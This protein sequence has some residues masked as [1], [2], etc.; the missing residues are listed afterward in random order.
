MAKF[1]DIRELAQQNARWVSNS[2]KDW[3]NYLDVAARLYRYSFKDTLL[4]HA[5]R[6]DA[7]ACAEL[8][9]WNKKMNRWVNRGAKG[10]AL[11]D[12][13]SPRA[14]LRY[15]FDI[16]DTHLVQG[17]RTPILWRIDD[18]EHQQMILDHLA[19]TY[20]LTQ[21]DSMNAALMELAQQ[22][23]AENLE[24]AMDGL[25]YEVADTFLE[26][27]DEDNLRVRFRE[28]MTNSIFYTLSRRC[29][30]EPLEVLEDEDFIRI[31]DF[32]QLP[33]LTFLGNAVSEQCEAVLF[34]IGREMRKIYKKEITQQLEKSVDSLYNTN[35]DFSTLKHETKENTT[36]GGQENGV[37]VL[38]QGRLSVPESGREGRAADY[39][40]V[41]DAAQ[42][43]PER[44]PQELVSEYADKRQ[45]EPAS[46]ADRG[47]SGEPDGNPA[48]QPE[49]EVS[50]TE[51]GEGPAG[52]GSTSEQ[53][54]GDGRRDRFEGIGVQL[55]ETTT[56]QDLSEAE[57]EI[58]SAFSFPDLPTVE[59][60]IR[61]IEEPIRAR[62]AEKIALDSEVVDEVLRTGSNR[63]K[64][65]LRLIYNFMVEKTP[66][67]Y[68]EFVKNEYGT[69][70]KG[71]EIGGAKYAVWFDDLGLRIA[72]G[73]TAKGG[74]IANASLS[75]EDVSNRIHELLR[76]GEYAPQAVLDAARQN[77]LQE[78]AQ[79][80][81][82]M[83]RDLADG[84][85][86][87]VFQD[88][89][90]FRGGFPELTDRLAG[91]LDDAAFLTDLNERLSALGEAYAEDKDLMRMHF[92]K[93][94]KVAALFQKF[95]KPYQNY[96]ARDGFHWNE[97]KKFITED[98]IN[99]YFTRGSNYSD[100]RLAIYSFFLNHEDKKERADFLKE[101]YGIG[102]SSHALCGADDSHE[103]HDGR[104]IS[105]ERGSYG[106]PDASVHLN[107]NQAAGRIDQLIRDSEYLKPADYSRM[108]AYERERMAM[109]VMGFYHQLPNDVE[110]PYPQ[111][112]Y[113]EEGRKALVEKLEAPE[114][115][116]EL[117]EQMDNALL[118][119]PLDSGEYERKAES[120]SI[121]HQYVE[122]TYTIFPEKKRA[123]E[124]AVPEQ[125]QM[126]MFDFMEQEPQ[127]KEQ[128][129]AAAV[130]KPQKAK[131]VARYQS[132]VM[133]QEGYIE[134]IAILQYPDGKFYNHY[135]YDEEKGTGA[136]ETGPFNS[137]NDAKSVIRQTREDA[138]AVESFENQP[139]QTYSRENGSFLYLENDHLYRV[140]RSNAYDVY[141]KDM[142]N[143]AV[144]G[145]VIPLPSYSETLAKNPLNDFLK[146]DADHTQ[147]DSR[148]VYK[149]CLYT[150]LEKVERSEI[151]PLLRDR[152]TTE[153]EA[154]NLIRE[155]IE[156]LFA[157]GE[158]EN[159][160]Y[161]EAI[162]TWAHFGEWIQEDIFQRTYQDVITDRRDAVALYQDS[163]D[164]PQWVRGIMV[165]YAAEEKAVEPTLQP[166]P[167][168]ETNEYNALK[169]RYPDALVGYE[170]HG[171][172][173]FYG[174][175]AKRV[176]E[177][178]G[179]KLLEKET[180]LGK[181]EVSGFP[182][183]QWASQAMKLW[184]Q[185]ESVYLSGQ[186][187]DGTHAQTKYFR[188]EEYLPINTTIELED[189]EFRV[190]SVNFEQGT[191]SL[192]D[193]TLA[194]EARYPIFRTEP[195]EYIRHVYEQADVPMEEAV[196]I[197]VFTALHNAGV[198][199]EDFSPEQM[200]VI[201]SVAE[202][203]G[204]LEDLLKPEFPP[205]QMQ[206]IAD[207]QNRTDAISRAAAEEALE[208]LTQQPM[209]PAEVNHARR[210]HNLPLDSEAETELPAQPKQEPMNFRITD[211]DLGAG[212]PKAKYKANVEA[213]RVLQTLDAEQ[214]QAA[215]AEE[216][217][218]LSRY[219]GWGGIPQAFDEKNADW[220]KEYAELKSLLPADEYS[221]ARAS[222][223]NAF[224]TSP[225]VIKAMYEALSNMGLSKGNV[226][227]PSCGV[228][229]F[230]GLVPESME[231]IKMYGV[232]LDNVSGRIAQQLYQ[233]NKIA[234]QGFETMQFPDSF[235]D[236]VV[237]NVPFGN[238]KVPDKRYDRHNFLIHDYFIAKSLDLVRP[239][240]VVAVVTSSGTMDKKDSSVRE[241]L[242][243]RADLVGAIRLPNNAFQRNANTSVVADIL[244][245][246]KRDRA[247]VE[248][249]EW[250]DLG[251][252][253]E[254][255]PI[256]QYF[257]Q[258]PEMVLGEITTESTQY[259]KQETTVKPIEGADLA[260]QLKAAVEN[261]NAEITEPEIT[262]D[263]LDQNA[264][265]LPADPNVKNFS[266]TNVDGQVYYR[267]NSYMNKVDLP[268]VTAERVLGMIALRETTQKL[269][270]CQLHDGT[271]AEVELLQGKLKD[272]YKRFTAQYGLINSTA[273]KRAFRQDSSYC[274]LA[275]LEIL[276]EDKNLKRLADIFTKRTIRKPEPVTSVDTPS[277][278]LALSIGEKA[279]V[280]V[281]F[282]AELCGKTEQEVTE[283]LAGVIFRN[284]V[285]Q[286]WVT[287]DEYL[288]G[289]VREKLETAET[290]AANHPEYQVNVEYLKRVQPKDLNASEIEVRL[291]ANWIKAEYITD[292]MERVF[293]T[294]S[295]YIGS[296]IK[297]TYSEISGAWNISGKSLDRSNPR[298]TNTYGTMRVNGYRLLEDALNLRDTK[299][300]D[301]IYEDGK[302]RRVLNKKET[303]L[304][305]QA[306]EAIRDAF[307]QWIFKD[308]D[309]REE[310]C[311]VYN[312]RFNAIRPREYD[313]SHI[314]FVGMTPE[315]SLMPHQKNAV[316]HI[317]Y[318]N[319]TLLA[320]CVGAGKTFQMIAAGMESRRLG[321]AQ[322][323]L[324]VV[325]NH[326]TEQWG[327]DF[328]RLYPNA[329]VLV[330]TKKDFEPA[331]RKKFCSRIATGDYDAIIIGH[332]QFERIPLSPERQKS[333][334][335]RQIQD[336]TFAIAEA[337]AEDDGKSF[338][339]KQMEK[340]KKTLQAKLQKL[341]D[342][343]RKDDVVT[344]EQLGVDRLFV[345]ESH[346][347]KNMFLYTKMRNIAGIAQTDAQKSSDMFAK[348]QYLDE[349]TGGKGVTFAT[350]T[351]VSNS[352]VE[353][354]T[355]MRYL[356]YDTLQKLHL[357]HFDSWAASFGE[358]VTAIE[359]SPEGTG[360]RAKTRFARFFNL[361]ELISLF[362]E[363]AD[364]QTA[365]M[366]NLP[367][368]EAEY[369]NEVLKPSET[370]QE[371]V[372]SFADRAERVRNGNVDPRTDNMLK[373]TNDGRKLALDQRLINDLLPDEP[374][375]KV[376]LCVENAY[377]VWEESTPDKSTQLIFCDLS[378]PKADGTFNVY[379]DVREKLVAKG[380][381]REEIAFIHEANTETKKAEL[382][383]K[384]RSGQVRILL[385]STPKLG[386][387]TNIQDRLI[388]LHHLDC[389]WKPSDLEQQE[390]RILRQGNRNQKVKIFRYVTE[391]TFDSYMWQILENK[392]KF[393]S[394]IMTSKSPVRAC[395]DVDDTALTY[396]E[397]KALATGNPYI[398]EKMDLDIQVSKLKL[399]RANHT[400]QIY[401]LESDIARRYPAEIT[402]AKERIAGL[403]ADLAVAKPL[404][405]QD[406]EK[407]SI[408]V[409]D[410]VYTDRK[411]AGSAILAACAAMKIAKT[412]GQIADLG[413]F[414]ISSRFDAF[415]QTFKLAIK[416]QSSYTIELGS[417]PAG[418]IQR[419]L[420][421]LASIEKTLPQVERRLETLQQQLAEA[422][423][424]VQRPFPQEAELNEKSA[425]LAELN[426]L[427]DMD[428]K[429]DDAALGMDEEVTDSELPAP[430]R[431]IERSADSVKRPS[432][433]AQLH[434]KQAERMAE[435]KP[436]KK[437]SHDMKL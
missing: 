4:I 7:T 106:N 320:H 39:R 352:M 369:I 398:K 40:E 379:D 316:A 378:T 397:I 421:A 325:P 381:P 275:S 74:T 281:P 95:A 273:N 376:N 19:D 58:A 202:S 226:L 184:K 389:P 265:P 427:L 31:V 363:S 366:L 243:N 213:I 263:E 306:Q 365:D 206:L 103:D 358:T 350:G 89:E 317:L 33:V 356:Q 331:N 319:N 253:P 251:T 431:E 15:V 203:G 409:E 176:S 247:A 308:L 434:E 212:G 178:L 254:G 361:P 422:K 328:L 274:L 355:I 51:Q 250:V 336:I 143:S 362:K 16:A 359:L 197:T 44:E 180:A 81:A 259:G 45:T 196:E 315:I 150:L 313:G 216:Q 48:G 191:V 276:D 2:P 102:G 430:K 195:L 53:P 218:I 298:V 126:S 129:T 98:E 418:N 36:K 122:G 385:G 286:A 408:T 405:E 65:Q 162:D 194:K 64:G 357:G 261:I 419:I 166:L 63:S 257:A 296:S 432:I 326:L 32:N 235:F 198:A 210:K 375:S 120:L 284:P 390:G 255:Y 426:A 152:D 43:V 228:G 1:N 167:L 189:R 347:Y 133:M 104:G 280:D 384:V 264:E 82:Y 41:R 282:M 112:L 217:E 69:G 183:E 224:Y 392:Q 225:T 177:L 96:S 329:N 413:G 79:T 295:Y 124:I 231:N 26:G 11:L 266:Y 312:E 342:Q 334:I 163:K 77:A 9:V 55:T 406:K 169:E 200:D 240:G 429:G 57:E 283:E 54:D 337:K 13:A 132:T 17:G 123:V 289:N 161:S 135:N 368:P 140:E 353:L 288:S 307:K 146:L 170:Q 391:N 87:A 424:E 314:K 297:A 24:E 219:V 137:L 346:F 179:S 324:Y 142:E 153:E 139:K 374:E 105:L 5:Q 230:M 14:K 343:S 234:V 75:W 252:T 131:V 157:S 245:L 30:Q 433:L 60:Q 348:C 395:D 330:A 301:T 340:T 304:A 127:S 192:Q 436:Q 190:D 293:K 278:A 188:R 73:G 370:Q 371:M 360:Y 182:R 46:G 258:H 20:A 115:A 403:K 84:V 344:F 270:D 237:G 172:F 155:K 402:A 185:G 149:E 354:Y 47:S 310:L 291:G 158:V 101:H 207:V 12:D 232:E 154:E 173:E 279:K 34:D 18:S 290:F 269:L 372:S 338:T 50:G 168:D 138:K 107:W 117:L 223:L 174:E 239:G 49:R 160:T 285:T 211:D 373:I 215:T 318:G 67:E 92:Y 128:S 136:A 94:D 156:D 339:V 99:A 109:R 86:E 25:E 83:E 134:D 205:E 351:P 332:S 28:L 171:N 76:Q 386:A 3:M 241:Y 335:E 287:A 437:K 56:E 227:E 229:N 377:Q 21:T 407:F 387:G 151:Y 242:A 272:Q 425:R 119:V 68:T 401:S 78:H 8:E 383:A 93:P 341:N 311:K 322:K 221:E 364:V 327:A 71:F 186:Q 238:Y 399:M 249:A 262:D 323:N 110:R 400:S 220:A 292:F 256:N 147:K 27:L 268:A 130:E 236:C 414:A 144:A 80:L 164:A 199:Y 88:V 165:P 116:V 29:E 416:R 305:Q 85:A 52:M 114:Q 246:Q 35:T 22:L 300:Y 208:P 380:I 420:N 404:L 201:Y 209:T 187:E 345:D 118:S 222:T 423:E 193:M 108:P 204:E 277:E 72:A 388:A 271:D 59:Q 303:M 6:P 309:R 267:E 302:E 244:F 411:E 321:L 37:D 394:Q 148:C 125:G 233:K 62:Y 181:V 299:I 435:P 111:D 38:P 367:V 410:R 159:A 382:F 145:R 10:I 90:I 415:A 428:E 248:R 66:E 396:A 412:E 393:I 70:G 260:Q 100:S 121:L 42:D 175:D 97:Y 294:P 349:I 214:R 333:M 417:D 91:L 61:A 141:L 23:T 113:H